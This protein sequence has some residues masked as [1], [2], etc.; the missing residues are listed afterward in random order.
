M[1]I[2]YNATTAT[3]IEQQSLKMDLNIVKPSLLVA[4]REAHDPDFGEIVQNPPQK[5]ISLDY[6]GLYSCVSAVY[7]ARVEGE[8][9]SFGTYFKHKFLNEKLAPHITRK[10]DDL[11]RAYHFAFKHELNMPN[12][13]RAHGLLTHFFLPRMHQGKVRTEPI[14]IINEQNKIEYVAAAPGIV[15][16]ELDKL[17]SDIEILLAMPLDDVEVFYYAAYIHLVFVK[18]HPFQDGNGRTAR[19]LEK[20]FLKEK[21]GEKVISFPIERNYYDNAGLYLDNIRKIGSDY[22][23]LDYTKALDFLLMSINGLRRD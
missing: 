14:F 7:S 18:M 1:M 3:A 19:L 12:L 23:H 11:Y 17:L 20:W 8:K 22:Q 4:Y 2:M 16:K 6:V 5:Y 21:L 10:I 9:V 13:L 15:S